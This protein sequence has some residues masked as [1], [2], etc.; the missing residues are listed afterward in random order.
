RRHR[1]R[2]ERGG[3]GPGPS[4]QPRCVRVRRPG[5][6]GAGRPERCGPAGTVRAALALLV[7]CRPAEPW[8]R[9]AARPRHYSVGRASGLLSSLRRS[10]AAPTPTAL[11]S[12]APPRLARALRATLL[13]VT[14][15]APEPRSCRALP[16][17]PRALRCRADVS[18]SWDPVECAVS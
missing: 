17:V 18:V 13:C 3:P 11:P 7:L 15:V 9:Q 8:Y 12:P 5:A 16:G 4:P 2:G 1:V 6:A 14:D 10:P